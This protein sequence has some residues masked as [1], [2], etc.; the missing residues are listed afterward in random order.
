MTRIQQI[1]SQ[2]NKRRWILMQYLNDNNISGVLSLRVKMVID[3]VVS[4]ERTRAG[5]VQL[6]TLLPKEL[7]EDLELES[8]KA[9][10]E[11]HPLLF[12]LTQSDED[13]AKRLSCAIESARFA[14][15]EL[16]FEK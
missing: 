13:L 15:N 1:Y 9:V 14:N 16:V 12:C 5:E 2:R 10:F 7:R 3:Q 8:K 6:L 11:A 4:Q